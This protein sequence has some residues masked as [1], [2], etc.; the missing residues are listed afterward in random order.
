[1]KDE[2]EVR[3]FFTHAFYLCDTLESLAA[4]NAAKTVAAVVTNDADAEKPAEAE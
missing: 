1:M 3:L 2:G 4:V